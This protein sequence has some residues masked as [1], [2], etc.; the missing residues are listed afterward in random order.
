MT[1]AST[2]SKVSYNGS[3]TVG[4]FPVTF[5]FIKNADIVATKRSSLGVETVL[6][7]TTGYTLTGAGDAA[8]G[9]LTLT[10]ALAVGESLVIAR[11]PGIVQEVDYVE[12]SAF[13]AET[14]E[15]ALD[16]LTMICQS[17]QEQVDRAVKVEISSTTDPDD[18]LAE[19]AADVVSAA[20][21]ASTATTQ[22]GL[23]A[24]AKTGAETARDDAS[25]F[26]DTASAGAG[27]ITANLAAINNITANLTAVQGAAANASTASTKASEASASAASASSSAASAAASAASATAIV[28]PS[29][30]ARSIG[31]NAYKN[32]LG[33]VCP[34]SLEVM[35]WDTQGANDGVPA[36]FTLTRATT[37]TAFGPDGALYTAAAGELRHEWDALTGEYKGWLLEGAGTNL[38][39]SSE[40]FRSAA[41]GNPI[42]AWV[43]TSC[44]VSADATTAP[45]GTAT[46]DKLVEDSTTSAKVVSQVSTVADN[47]VVTLSVY[48]KAAENSQFDLYGINTT[49]SVM[50]RY[51]LTAKTA[52]YS[53]KSG[54]GVFISAGIEDVGNSW[55]RCSLTYQLGSGITA[56]NN[57]IRFFNGTTSSYAGNGVNGF[58][59]WGAQAEVGYYPTSY[60]AATSATVTRAADMLTIATS[61]FPFNA[62][63]GTLYVE[64]SLYAVGDTPVRVAAAIENSSAELIYINYHDTEAGDPIYC[65][66][67]DGGVGQV[68][69]KILAAT[70]VGTFY[71]AAIGYKP[72]DTGVA[73][74]GTATTDTSCTTPTVTTLRIGSFTGSG[75]NMLHGHVKHVAYFPRRL[76][77]AELALLTK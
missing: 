39:K 48:V 61:A 23:A 69:T 65:A 57:V 33:I 64:S 38:L 76:S 4:P 27:V 30:Y 55:Y 63:E 1:I 28:N 73:G 68:S 16:L 56:Y 71:K 41:A 21:S 9:A 24:T 19:L 31:G 49:N 13:P 35:A 66:V 5:K 29:F 74:E 58:Y 11:A 62:V 22:A 3:G 40:D 6:A 2:T 20:A 67:V 60:I 18:L 37:A 7:L 26:A 52:A 14:H 42:T 47:A 72:N 15:G 50:A 17:L 53:T 43:N 75:T 25:D 45:D 10:V 32:I 70:T 77:N 12:N 34:P 36:G 46:A 51:N 59:V 8:G 44:T 54:N